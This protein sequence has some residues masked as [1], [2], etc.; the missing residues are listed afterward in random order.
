M[1][2]PKRISFEEYERMEALRDER[3]E[4]YDG[5][6][7][8]MEAPSMQHEMIVTNIGD[9]LAAGTRRLGCRKF[10]NATVITPERPHGFK[11]DIAIS[12][13][14]VDLG[15]GDHQQACRLRSPSLIVEVLSKS[16][17]TVDLGD[18]VLEYSNIPSLDLYLVVDSRRRWSVYYE[19]RSDGEMTSMQQVAV[20]RFTPSALRKGRCRARI[21]HIAHRHAVDGLRLP[22]R[23]SKQCR[24]RGLREAQE[25]I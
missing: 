14:A 16:T 13:D 17:A 20:K 11:P 19:R 25:Q 24:R 2:D 5:V 23:C 1:E 21:A 8:R 18:K 10:T 7:V 4:Y 9:L 6:V 22:E 3:L 12:C 15:P